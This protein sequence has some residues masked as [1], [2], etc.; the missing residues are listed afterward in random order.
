MPFVL[1]NVI[2]NMI[3]AIFRSTG[4]GQ[5]LVI[6]TVIYSLAR[7][8]FSYLLYGKYKMYGIYAAIVL[9]WV[10][11][12]L[13]G[14]IIYFSGIWKDKEYKKAEIQNNHQ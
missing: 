7:F 2:N 8:G 9:S 11:E 10:T 4:A 13:F 1:F 5:Y 14:L 12:A 6:S 3:H